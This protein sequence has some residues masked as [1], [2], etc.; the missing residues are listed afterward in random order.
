MK[1]H[2][3][4]VTSMP[5]VREAFETLGTVDLCEG[6]SLAP[7]AIRQADLLAIRSTT[8]IDRA[9]LEGSR[10]RFVGTATIGTDHLDRA[11]LDQAGIRW[12]YAPGCNA[13]SVAEYV[14]AALL[15]LAGRHGFELAGRTIGIVGVGNVGSRVLHK[16][17][18][19]G[20]RVLANDPPRARAGECAHP[21]A[22]P[23]PAAPLA[24]P[25]TGA[26]AVP[27]RPLGDVLAESD[28]VTLHTPLTREGADRT[29]HLADDAF[30][31]ALRPGAILINAAR[32]PIVDSDA[33]RR[34]MDR[35]IVRHAVLD[36]WEGEPDFPPDLLER[37]DI[38]T[39]HIAGY[40]FEGK[41]MGTVM[42]YREACRF[43]GAE[44]AWSVAPLLPPPTV[45]ALRLPDQW[46]G[47]ED[48]LRLA[49]R[50]VYDI[51]ADDRA[52]RAG[53]GGDTAARR[54]HF[55]RLRNT[56][57]ER[58]EFRFSTVPAGRQP[59]AALAALHGLGFQAG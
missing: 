33:L 3:A 5:Y 56:Y 49:V 36:T 47:L 9:L 52:L 45:P 12:C 25:A 40:S 15:C 24:A 27:F 2:T 29:F 22:D 48:L 54:R 46:P 34:A 26:A 31:A 42:V 19:L 53:A 6:R 37:C 28:I 14:T 21:V 10:V 4:A 18:A 16:A 39:P 43:L 20:L 1:V 55:D 51:E 44:P 41:V 13:N 59:P 32:G 8:R 23:D 7:D 58:R 57:P 30:F 50:Q 17:Q 35:G 38:G 11:Y